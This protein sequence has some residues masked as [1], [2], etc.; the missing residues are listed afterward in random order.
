[1]EPL[2]YQLG[3]AFSVGLLSSGHCAGMCGGLSAALLSGSNERTFLKALALSAGRVF[4]YAVAGFLVA[5]T[6]SALTQLAE[7]KHWIVTTQILAGVMVILAGLYITGW[8]RGLTYIERAGAGIWKRL[9]RLAKAF[10]P[11]RTIPT[12]FCYGLVWG[13]LPCGLVYS[14]LTWN[15]SAEAAWHGAAVMFCFGLGTLP[16]MLSL[17]ML[18][19]RVAKLLSNRGFRNLAGG[20]VIAL[21]L[22]TLLSALDRSTW[23]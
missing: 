7:A 5:L 1:M 22:F 11:I 20:F 15:L 6:A 16:S 3:A 14:T 21:G 19:N 13:W 12:A 23:F 2:L 8:Y 10:L 9:Q 17:G 4:S 18:G